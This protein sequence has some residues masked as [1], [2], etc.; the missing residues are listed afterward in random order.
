MAIITA[1]LLDTL[2]VGFRSD[3]QNAY[4][5]VAA[6]RERVAMTIRSTT[7][8]NMY[9]WMKELP[10][11]R[12][13]IGPRQVEN[14][15]EASYTIV[16][17]DYEETISVSRNQIEDDNLGQFAQRFAMMGRAVASL[18][19]E[20]IWNLV[21][22][23]FTT[24]CWDGQ[25]FF[26][27]DHPIRGADGVMTT[28]SNTGGGAGTAWYLMCTTEPLKPFIFQERKAPEF[29]A[30]DRKED[31]NTFMNN[32]YL[33]GTHTRC[34]VG[35]GLPQLAYGSKQT[36]DSANYK[37]ARTAI[38]QMKGDY[39]RPLGLMPNLLVVPPSLEEAGRKLLNSEYA[40]GGETNPW[41]G[42]AEL[43]VVP[44]LS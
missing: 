1:P 5:M 3:F 18:P 17:K 30:K 7:A 2:R 39:G 40:T 11:M 41:K 35:F 29:V 36:L 27:A 16:N 31:D 42:T 23:G 33:Y 8:Q 6:Q 24:N 37:A 38:M 34:A 43:L 25:F 4:G 19:E 12:E 15:E 13:W 32:A 44:R 9:G 20:L 22:S 10:S 14:L 21:A 28:Y 26:D